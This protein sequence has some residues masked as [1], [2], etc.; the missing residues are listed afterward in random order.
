MLNSFSALATPSLSSLLTTILAVLHRRSTL[1][2]TEV[3]AMG[4]V[5]RTVAW[6]VYP[7]TWRSYVPS[8]T[9]ANS[10]PNPDNASSEDVN[11][12][13]SFRFNFNLELLQL[14]TDT[15]YVHYSFTVRSNMVITRRL[16]PPEYTFIRIIYGSNR[17]DCRRH[18]LPGRTVGGRRHAAKLYLLYQSDKDFGG[19]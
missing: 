9:T 15:T 1:L 5:I 11:P 3:R 2:I 13:R 18:H 19:F 14:L 10:P 8:P 7:I 4:G 6:C 12:L 17:P 16:L